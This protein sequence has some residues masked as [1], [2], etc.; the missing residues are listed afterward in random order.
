MSGFYDP[1]FCDSHFSFYD[2][3][4]QQLLLP[5]VFN[6]R[7]SP[8]DPRNSQQSQEASGTQPSLPSTPCPEISSVSSEEEDNGKKRKLKPYEKWTHVLT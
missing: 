3:Q 1:R 2:M 5:F 8:A 7:T 4:Q 6:A